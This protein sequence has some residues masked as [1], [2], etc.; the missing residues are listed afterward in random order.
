MNIAPDQLDEDRKR[1]FTEGMRV[2]RRVEHEL[3]TQAVCHSTSW[4]QVGDCLC[5]YHDGRDIP[6]LQADL[7]VERRAE[8]VVLPELQSQAISQT[9]LRRSRCDGDCGMCVPG[10]CSCLIVRSDPSVV[11]NPAS[12]KAALGLPS[13]IHWTYKHTVRRD[14]P[15]C[16]VVVEIACGLAT[17]R[18]PLSLP[19]LQ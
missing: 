11:C 7:C 3:R 17:R 15:G 2:A 13:R 12:T 14:I 19:S 16:Q 4:R 9:H 1:L 10:S 18:L 6:I 5:T 8:G